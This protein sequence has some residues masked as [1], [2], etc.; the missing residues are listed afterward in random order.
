MT[1]YNKVGI[2]NRCGED[3]DLDEYNLCIVCNSVMYADE[4]EVDEILAE[5]ILEHIPHGRMDSFT[6]YAR[7]HLNTIR[8]LREWNRVLVAGGKCTIKVPNV[9]G[10]V[11]QYVKNNISPRDF[12]MYMYGGQEYSE[13]THYCGF[14]PETLTDV[15]QLAGFKDIRICNAHDTNQALNA[16]EAWEMTAIGI[17]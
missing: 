4:E 17:K 15:M 9:R 7:A 2:C 12:W 6:S 16:D 8:V 14:D 10:L 13:N 3:R 11:M 5:S 1:Q